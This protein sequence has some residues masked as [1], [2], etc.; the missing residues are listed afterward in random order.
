MGYEAKCVAHANGLRSQ[1]TARL[2]HKTI[3]FRGEFRFSIPLGAV[4]DVSASKGRLRIVS[5]D[6][7][8]DFELGASADKWAAIIRH[9]KSRAEKLGIKAGQVVAVVALKTPD[10]M[11]ELEQ[12]GA[13]VETRVAAR[14]C[15]A[16]FYGANCTKDLDKL[17]ALKQGLTRSG[18]LWVVRPKGVREIT[19]AQVMAAGK[20]AGL[21]DVKVVSFSETHTAEK[22][23]IP[24]KDRR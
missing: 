14:S 13:R 20:S 19:E 11:R 21:V 2:E 22:F 16:V 24:V 6:L 3:E 17:E 1:G 10:F 9:P 7:T 5:S 4:R 8:A 18:A 15:D 23:V 12:A